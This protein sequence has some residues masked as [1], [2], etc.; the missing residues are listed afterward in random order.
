MG[1]PSVAPAYSGGQDRGLQRI[2]RPLG[3]GWNPRAGTRPA[4]SGQT[5]GRMTEWVTPW[6]M[7]RRES[8][9][10][11]PE[12]GQ[13]ARGQAELLR[14]GQLPPRTWWVPYSPAHIPPLQSM[15]G[16]ASSW[17][18]LPLLVSPQ[19]PW[20]QGKSHVAPGLTAGGHHGGGPSS[21]PGHSVAHSTNALAR[22]CSPKLAASLEHMERLGDKQLMNIS[23]GIMRCDQG[24]PTQQTPGKHPFTPKALSPPWTQ[25]G[26]VPPVISP[27]SSHHHFLPI[28]PRMCMKHGR[29]TELSFILEERWPLPPPC[30][31]ERSCSTMKERGNGLPGEGACRTCHVPR[32]RE[33]RAP[34]GPAA[35]T[36]LLQLPAHISCYSVNSSSEK[37]ELSSSRVIFSWKLK[38]STV[39]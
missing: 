31:Q 23:T 35:Q 14:N 32:P 7:S 20:P 38:S 24:L 28:C 10:S 13:P 5:E 8:R 6:W 27:N 21:S 17:G 22:V 26:T 29:F 33:P 1:Q 15:A 9:V 11:V 12:R 39:G 30:L 25:Q 37:A 18:S 4:L 19:K 3:V 16:A 34:A 2:C 36:P